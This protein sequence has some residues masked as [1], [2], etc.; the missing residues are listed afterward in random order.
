MRL[1][2]LNEG[3]CSMRSGIVKFVIEVAMKLKWG[4]DLQVCS[5]IYPFSL[6]GK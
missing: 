2:H 4:L 3:W 5:P 6:S 1:K